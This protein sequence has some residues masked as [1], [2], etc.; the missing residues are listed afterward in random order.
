MDM[1]ECMSGHFQPHTLVDQ[2]SAIPNTTC[3]HFLESSQRER[4]APTDATLGVIWV[5]LLP[6]PYE[7][8][9]HMHSAMLGHWETVSAKVRMG[10]E[11]VSKLPDC[12]ESLKAWEHLQGALQGPSPLA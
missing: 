5:S 8:T 1:G 7:E 6:A 12:E 2:C 10:V 3:F 9:P 4:E 11:S